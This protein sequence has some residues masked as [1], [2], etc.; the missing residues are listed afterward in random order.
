[1]DIRK[2]INGISTPVLGPDATGIAAFGAGIVAHQIKGHNST[3]IE[4]KLPSEHLG[5]DASVEIYDS[6][7]AIVRKFIL[8]VLGVQNH[9]SWDETDMTGKMAGQGMYAALLA[10][11][12]IRESTRFMI[13]R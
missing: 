5:K 7:G 2:I 3:F 11:E 8:K 9:F 10:S 12:S 13:V 1:M 4:F 6:R